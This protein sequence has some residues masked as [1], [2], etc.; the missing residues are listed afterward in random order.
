MRRGHRSRTEPEPSSP[1]PPK[2]MNQSQYVDID[3]A[4]ERVFRWLD[5]SQRVMEWVEGVVENEDLEV[6]DGRVGSTFRQ[7][8]VENGRRMEFHGRVTAYER[9]RSLGVHLV[10]DL[11]DLQVDYSLD[12][13]G[14]T[15]RLTQDSE[16][17]FKG[18]WKLLGVVMCKLAKKSGQRKLAEDFGRLKKLCEATS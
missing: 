7:V 1:R 6:V 11:F 2:A 18:L 14:G 15:T 3:A 17:R 4:P 9:D 12:A 10:G 16:V 13:Q 8:Y 5:D